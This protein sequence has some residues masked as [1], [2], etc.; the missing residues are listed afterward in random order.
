VEP[1]RI[2]KSEKEMNE[3]QTLTLSQLFCE[4]EY[5]EWDG[6]LICKFCQKEVGN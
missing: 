1:V 4:H 3:K 6:K 5:I 2:K